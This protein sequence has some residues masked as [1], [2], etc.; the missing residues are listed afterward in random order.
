[1]AVRV[2]VFGGSVMV[3]VATCT[4]ALADKGVW[5]CGCG[6]SVEWYV[7]CVW[8]T[9]VTRL[10]WDVVQY[11][12]LSWRFWRLGVKVVDSEMSARVCAVCFDYPI[13]L[14]IGAA[15]PDVLLLMKCGSAGG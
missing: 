8:R 1:V 3:I 2:V 6:P 15:W 7:F 9:Y 11:D 12:M 4:D 13:M 14:A 5:D 10:K